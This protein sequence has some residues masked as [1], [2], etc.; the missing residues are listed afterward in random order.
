MK[1]TTL[2]VIIGLLHCSAM[3]YSQKINLKESN[4]PLQKVLQQINKQTGYVF[5]YDSKDLKDKNVS[6]VLKDASIDQALN[7]CLKGNALQYKVI[8]KTVLLQ[9]A[10]QSQNAPAEVAS[11]NVRGQVVD[12]R[13]VPLPGVSIRIKDGKSGTVTDVEGK[14]SINVADDKAVLIFSYVGFATREIPAAEISNSVIKLQPT[15]GGLQEVVVTSFGIKRQKESLGYATSNV[16][17]K[18]ITE[19][20]STNFASALYGKVAGVTIRTQPGGASSA[21][22]VQIRGINSISYNQPPL[23]VVDGVIIRNQQQYGAN[24]FNNQ[25]FYT[26]QRIEGNGVLDINPND[27]ENISVL[28]GGAATALYGSDAEGG[29][30]V[31]TT[32]KGTRGKGPTVDFNYYGTMEQAAFLPNYQNVYGQGYDRATN[33]A[34]GFNADGSVPD[35]KSP[36]GWRP[37]F[38]AYADFGPKMEGQQVRWWD[39]SIQSYS[40]Q[41]DNYKDI[42][43]TG[44][45]SSA[46]V[47]LSNQTDNAN[48][49]ISYT[50]LDY[51]GI[52]RES[53][54]HKNT[55]GLNS[56]LNLSKK[57]SV[58][59]VANYV[60]TITDN[61]PYQTNRLAQSFDG[62]FGREE[63]MDLVRQK[64]LTSQ[65]Y[66]YAP[67][68]NP[69][70]NPAEAFIF[71]VRPNLYDYF[72]STLKNTYTETENRIYSSATLNWSVIDHLKFR[73]RIGN[74][75]TGRNTDAENYNTYPVAFNSGNSSTGAYNVSSG[76]YSI[77]YGDALLTYEHDI[78]KDF[79]FSLSGGFTARHES[80]L[81]QASGTT[82]GLVTANFFS[83]NNSYGILST[84]YTRQYLLKEGSFALLDLSFKKYLFLEGAFRQE[85][86]STLPPQNNTYYYPAVNGSFIFS[87]ALK[88][89]MP[90]F[91]SYGKLRLSYTQNGNPA[92]IYTSNIAYA[93]TSLQTINGSVSQLSIPSAYG[94]N[95]LKPERKHEYEA[96]LELRF[97]N[98][99]IGADVSYYTN[100]INDQIL[101]LTV[102]PSNGASSQIVNVG[103]IGNQGVE[104][105]LNATPIA[106]HN[107]KW[108]VRMNYSFNKTKV[109]A[110]A[111]NEPELDFYSTEGNSIKVTAKP[112]ETLGNIY[113]YPIATDSKGNK[114]IDANGYYIMDQSRYVKVGNI[115]PKAVGGFTNTFTYKRFSLTT[116]IDYRL[117][118]QL[119]STPL[120]YGIS[121]GMYTSTLKY[122]DAA[123]GGLTYYTNSAGVN[124]Q[125]A[126]NA[127]A[128][129]NGETVYHDGLIQP[130]VLAN[131]QA[132]NIILDAASYYENQ[133]GAG[134][135]NSINDGV[136]IYNNSYVKMREIALG[137]S[138]PQNFVKHIGLSRARF[139]LIGRNLFYIYR[140]LKNLDPE[141]TLGSQ[142][143]NQGIDNGSIPATRSYGFSLNATF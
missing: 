85:S 31:I 36:A 13:N 115:L 29:V 132:N 96:G 25:G 107:F 57:V 102:A 50:R 90:S 141:T 133:F 137:Y 92:P 58:D 19:A 42:F 59:V 14:F 45:S 60:N 105:A 93:Q 87:D 112:G 70:L 113:D 49:R 130:G 142:W 56:T 114:L 28:K 20:G 7:E 22:S 65:G 88:S 40:P 128:G 80:Y 94:N 10:D 47:S 123:H 71:R 1:L 8:N 18:D 11:I 24:G 3:S 17:G 15:T 81:D 27:I 34:L 99:R 120:K 121:S 21:V 126:A 101:P 91:L 39:G 67:A 109:Y 35:P 131:G 111:P 73:A 2:I 118:G 4:A 43:R 119:I 103:T 89:I 53:G 26:D 86:A 122:R 127:T 16:S 97:L 136:A 5:F 72:F 76:I 44:Y 98:D 6:I 143:Y 23:Y 69:Q 62:F 54:V 95:T 124:V 68:E 66:E 51:G 46:N 63:K 104:V 33:L 106:S 140:T 82:N 139:S 110:L 30:I 64:F 134:D 100:R 55:F 125:L 9:V 83:L 37:N 84:S 48:Y 129:P 38:R 12:D 138:L 75:Y 108:D 32:K 77:L 78:T 74:D 41:P 79:N 52:Q 61:R 117:G 135:P 116:L